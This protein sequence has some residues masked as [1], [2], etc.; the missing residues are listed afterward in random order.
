M[1]VTGVVRPCFTKN[2]AIMKNKANLT[3][4]L[5]SAFFSAQLSAQTFEIYVSDAGNFNLPPWQILK[6]D[7]NGEN[8]SV[9]I[10]DHLDWPQDILFLE[11]SNT[12]LVANLNSG[13]ISQFDATTGEFT[14]E[15]ATG[16]GGPT[17]MEIGPDSLLYVLQWQGNGKVKR[18]QLDGTFVD[19]FTDVGVPASIGL[20]WDGDG[21][22]YVSSYNGKYVRKFG[23][24][25][26]DLGLF[27]STNLAGP[28][29]IWFGDNGDLFVLDY[30]GGAVK[31]FDAQGN[32]LGVFISNLPQ[33]EGVDFLP[34]GNLVIGCGGT[35]SIRVYDSSGT[36]V[37][38]LVPPGT[39]NL[40]TPNAVVL[41]F[42]TAS[43]AEEAPRQAGQF[44]TPSIGTQFRLAD[45][46]VPAD[47]APLEVYDSAGILVAKINFMRSSNWDASQL[48]NGVYH[49]VARLPDGRLASQRIVVQ[50]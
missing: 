10:D 48:S 4:W 6:F 24:S 46:A 14:G 23:T 3:A 45:L 16:I 42:I 11:D 44:V 39:L 36:L 31:R 49:L 13:R 43:G 47:Q 1:A 29:N 21:N 41:R 20:D 32:F 22:L 40:L 50:H 5:L 28:T 37:G 9:F 12:A 33:G 26:E 8:G 15:F 27:A 19:D 35:S 18:Y 7:Q 17:R 38:D 25:G 34:D 2:F 30:N